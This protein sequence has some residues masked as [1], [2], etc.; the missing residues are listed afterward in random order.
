MGLK[1]SR[2]AAY[3][4]KYHVVWVPKDRR[5]VL[6]GR[7]AK[8]LREICQGIAERYELEIDTQAVMEDHV[9]MFLS[10]SPRYAPSQVVQILKSISARLVFQ[11]FPEVKKQLWGGEL[12]NDRFF[13]RS[14][15]DKVTAEVI[16][17]YIKHQHD[18]RQLG[19]DF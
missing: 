9:H 14:V 16:R 2:G 18:P 7:L 5:M 19:F 13:V 15:G 11:E 17:H 4:L 10:A 1:R 12:W 8:R 6:K 3:D